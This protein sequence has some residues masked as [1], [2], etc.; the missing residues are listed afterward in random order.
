VLP[1]E[2]ELECALGVSPSTRVKALK[3]EEKP[4]RYYVIGVLSG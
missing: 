1:G 3:V 4:M 2:Q